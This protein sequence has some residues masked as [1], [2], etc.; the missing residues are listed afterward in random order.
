MNSLKVSTRL[1]AGFGLLVVLLLTIS[2]VCINGLSR[3]HDS[4]EQI[5][6]FDS[7]EARLASTLRSSI[8][9]TA[10][11]VR[12]VVLLTDNAGMTQEAE[13]VTRQKERYR[14]T[15]DELAQLLKDDPSSSARE[16]DLLSAVGRSGE[17]VEPVMQKAIQHGLAN[18]NAV[19]TKVLIEEVRPLQ[20]VWLAQVGELAD[21][22]D[23]SSAESADSA[24]STYSVV[25][26]SIAVFV[27]ISIVMAIGFGYVIT[28][29]LLRQLGGEP[30]VAQAITA[31]IAGG[32]LA[33]RVDVADGNSSSLMASVEAMRAQLAG[34]VASIKTTSDSI[35]TATREIAQGNLDL[36]AR[37]EE[38]ASSL[39]ETA[40]S[41]TE[42]TET[43][44]QNADNAR[45]ANTL[46]ARA[47]GIAEA[48]N[49]A[50]LGMVGTI[51]EISESSTKISEIT[52]TIEGIA[53]QTNI[54]A[55][56]AAVEAARA[57]EQG[58]GFA[59]VASEV[60][61]LA[62]RSAAAAKEIKEL[63]DASVAKIRAGAEEARD[64]GETMGEV[65]Q[66]I[67]QVS[68]IVGEIAAA[69]EEQSRGIEQVNQAVGQM[70]AVTQQ[71]AALV[72]QSAAAAQSL[73]EQAKSLADAVSAFRLADI[74]PSAARVAASSSPLRISAPKASLVKPAAAR[75]PVVAKTAAVAAASGDESQE[76]W[77]A[78]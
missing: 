67:K 71:N 31:E 11:A 55:L 9:D 24:A 32:N 76:A 17:A 53:F 23:K 12:N 50:V 68:D 15:Y 65:K 57:G 64:V 44:K 16:R 18:D 38:Q 72:E 13:R 47:T 40:S 33:V 7:R 56:N 66:A 61:S 36:S 45:Q 22:E 14:K 54:L 4:L 34:V 51:G 5:A 29:G 70:D 2:L 42:L 73:D 58:R 63:I 43:V 19:A 78:F 48:G 1:S 46:A 59:V 52:S 27:V 69:S 6:N 39:E 3:L 25:R 8:Q 41:M 37:T 10:V 62:Q 35:A 30:S 60:R 49:D 74:G 28:R 20:K 77:D 26:L 21:I 75:R